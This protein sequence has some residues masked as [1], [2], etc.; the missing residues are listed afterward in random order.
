MVDDSVN[1]TVERIEW[2]GE[3]QFNLY[4]KER[5]L[6]QNSPSTF[7]NKKTTAISSLDFTFRSR[8][9]EI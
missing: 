7:A 5:L 8:Q 3:E 9:E 1:E 4:V 2:N 6:N